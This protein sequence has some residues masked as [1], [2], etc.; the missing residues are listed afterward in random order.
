MELDK[1]KNQSEDNGERDKEPNVRASDTC[2]YIIYKWNL[3]IK[4]C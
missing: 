2:I 1:R 4:H 3:G